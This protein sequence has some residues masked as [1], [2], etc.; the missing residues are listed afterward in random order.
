MEL[1]ETIVVHKKDGDIVDVHLVTI[2]EEN[3][4]K[5]SMLQRLG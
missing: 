5:A 2:E 4:L 3:F 1:L